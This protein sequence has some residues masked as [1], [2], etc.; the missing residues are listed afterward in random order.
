MEGNQNQLNTKTGQTTLKGKHTPFH[1]SST[2]QAF[3]GHLLC[4]LP[5]RPKPP[6][7]HS[8]NHLFGIYY[9]VFFIYILFHP[10]ELLTPLMDAE[11]PTQWF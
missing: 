9:V 2:Y 7:T 8:I 1:H 5:G 10:E 3:L 11:L 6:V 4:G